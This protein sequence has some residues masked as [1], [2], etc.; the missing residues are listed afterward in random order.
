MTFPKR[1]TQISAVSILAGAAGVAVAL[2]CSAAMGADAAAPAANPA[3]AALAAF[4]TDTIFPVVTAL[5]MGVV[6]IFLNR[7]GAKYKIDA[8]TQQGNF[9]ERLAYQGITLAEERAAQ[10][11]GSKSTLTGR[12]KLDIAV[13]HVLSVMPKVGEASARR[14]VESLLAQIPGAGATKDI[15]YARDPIPGAVVLG[16]VA[17]SELRQ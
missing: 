15:A 10:Y 11:V 4:L 17:P 2:F 12:D 3:P 1:F 9:L 8:L 6:T 7:L 5:F 13:G 16:E 14:L